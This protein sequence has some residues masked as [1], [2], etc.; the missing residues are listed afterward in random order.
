MMLP[1]LISVSVAPLSYFFW[2]SAAPE[3]AIKPMTAAES[4]AT[5][6]FRPESMA[7]PWIFLSCF[8][9]LV[10]LELADQIVADHRD[11]PCPVWHQEDD[12]E[13][14]HAEHRA[15][16]AFRNSLSDVRNEDDEGRADDRTG[17]PSDAADNH[18]EKQRNR[19]RDGVAVG[20]HELHGDR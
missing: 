14:Q 19:Q 10:F 1:I 7:S 8:C 13:Q 4:A 17:Q 15:G 18:A 9:D 16:Q 11:L 3:V 12:E 5:V 2:A 20:S 6:S